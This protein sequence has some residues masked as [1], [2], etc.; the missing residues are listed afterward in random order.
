MKKKQKQGM[1]FSDYMKNIG[2]KTQ[3]K[4]IAFL[5]ER[6]ALMPFILNIQR[7]KNI[8]QRPTQSIGWLINDAFIW[9]NTSEGHVYWSD[10]EDDWS[11]E[12]NENWE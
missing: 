2:V 9:E 3:K 10:L 11:K 1:L 5:K 4:F 6:D 7:S 8:M 12:L